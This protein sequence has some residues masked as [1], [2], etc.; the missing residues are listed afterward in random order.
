MGERTERQLVDAVDAYLAAMSVPK[1]IK[2]GPLIV[3][4]EEELEW[5]RARGRA[6]AELWKALGASR[7]A[8]RADLSP[9]EPETDSETA[10]TRDRAETAGGRAR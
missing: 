7:E 5:N 3:E 8:L 4:Q 9:S 2:P 1:P 6:S 10:A